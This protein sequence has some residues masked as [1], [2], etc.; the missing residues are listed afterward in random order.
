MVIFH[1]YVSL[2]E[3]KW[4]PTWRI[5]AC[6]QFSTLLGVVLSTSLTPARESQ[7]PR[8]ASDAF[9]EIINDK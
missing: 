4:L 7:V 9:N 8:P 6:D 5:P 3:G 1:S 2:P